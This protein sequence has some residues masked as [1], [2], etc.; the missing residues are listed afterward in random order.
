[1][2]RLYAPNLKKRGSLDEDTIVDKYEDPLK[3]DHVN[4]KAVPVTLKQDGN[5]TDA[6]TLSSWY[7]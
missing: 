5:V 2:S 7:L 3:I 4:V 6:K 1:M